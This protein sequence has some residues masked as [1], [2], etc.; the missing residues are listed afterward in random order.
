VLALSLEGKTI[1]E[2][3]TRDAQGAVTHIARQEFSLQVPVNS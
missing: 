1:F 3:R 2:E